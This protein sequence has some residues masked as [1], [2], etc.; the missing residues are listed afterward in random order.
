MGEWTLDR[1]ALSGIML[2]EVPRSPETL[3]PAPKK[4]KTG[5]YIGIV[6][7]VLVAFGVILGIYAIPRFFSL[8]E[9]ISTPATPAKPIH[10]IDYFLVMEEGNFLKGQFTLISE[11]LDFLSSDGTVSFLIL[12]DATNKTIYTSEFQVKK[13]DFKYY[14]TLLGKTVLAYVWY[15]PISNVSKGISYGVAKLTFTAPD[16]KTCSDVAEYVSIPK[17]TEEEAKQMFENEY[18]SS[19]TMVNMILTVEDFQII[20]I[21]MGMF[22]RYTYNDFERAFRVDLKVKNIRSGTK[23]FSTYDTTLTTT[24]GLQYES[25]FYG[26]FTSGDIAGGSTKEGYLLF[27]DVPETAKI[28]KLTIGKIYIFDLEKG[29]TYTLIEMY[30][31]RYLQSAITVQQTITKG[32]F[33]I[34]L[35]RVGHF[36]HLEYDTWGEEVAEFRVDLKVTNIASEPE[37]IFQSDIV[38][39]D[40]LGNQYNYEYG[41]TL[42]LGEIYPGVTREGYVLFPALNENAN[43]ITVTITDTEYPED[44]VY[45]FTVNL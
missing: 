16:G 19:A 23:S 34:T 14:E 3:E 8:F 13:S 17:Y 1:K 25:S 22:S 38:I 10:H 5:L 24:A 35:V 27:D 11:D 42:E 18:T 31:N 28:A 20:V 44:I 37:Y 29:E 41:G 45:E 30:E 40:N 21:K 4:R 15:I 7:I 33:S 39:L 2:T 9:S 12:D 36:T 32:H 43:R 26:T 6:L